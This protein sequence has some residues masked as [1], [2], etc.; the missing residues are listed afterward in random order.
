MCKCCRLDNCYPTAER[1]GQPA[2]G[3]RRGWWAAGPTRAQAGRRQQGRQ[4]EAAPARAVLRPAGKSSFL[5][6]ISVGMVVA[7]LRVRIRD[8]WF[9]NPWIRKKIYGIPFSTQSLVKLF[10]SKILR[11]LTQIFVCTV[12]Y[13]F[14]NLPNFVKFMII[15]LL[16]FSN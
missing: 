8:L 7:A 12:R 11:K 5:G 9:F 4:Q 14:K 1:T 10:Q 15:F 16:G 2:G 3:Q 6:R 13:L